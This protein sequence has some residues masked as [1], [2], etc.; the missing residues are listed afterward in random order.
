MALAT[1]TVAYGARER[2]V[3][4]RGR[5]RV[6]GGTTGAGSV[7]KVSPTAGQR[8]GS[9]DEVVVLP[10]RDVHRP[11]GAAGLAELA[12]AVERIDDPDPPAVEAPGVLEP[13]LGQHG[14]V[15][16]QPGAARRR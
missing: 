8:H 9:G 2:D 12:G 15:G 7:A 14:V 1:K 3:T 4:T 13:F 10:E 5:G 6:V 16:P 11:V